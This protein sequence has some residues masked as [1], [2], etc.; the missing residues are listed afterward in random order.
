MSHPWR[1]LWGGDWDRVKPFF[2]GFRSP[3]EVQR[4]AIPTIRS[5]RDAL[6]VAPTAS[7]KTEAILPPLLARYHDE[8]LPD[9]GP[10]VLYVAPTRALVAD[11]VHRIRD[12]IRRM[13]GVVGERTSDRRTW[14]GGDPCTV[15]VTTPESLDS[16]TMRSSES[17]S[18][19]QGFITDEMHLLEGGPRGLQLRLVLERIEATI[20]RRLQHVLAS[21]TLPHLE[22]LADRWCVD[23]ELIEVSGAHELDVTLVRRD[24]LTEWTRRVRHEIERHESQKVLAFANS[25]AGVEELATHLSDELEPD[26]WIVRTHHSSLSRDERIQAEQLFH[27]NTQILVVATSTLEV[28]IDIGDVE[29]VILDKPPFTLNSFLQ[30]LGRGCRRTDRRRVVGISDSPLDARVFEALTIAGRNGRSDGKLTPPLFSVAVQQI[31][32]SMRQKALEADPGR[33]PFLARSVVEGILEPGLEDATDKRTFLDS[34]IGAAVSLD[35]VDCE[36]RWNK[37][38]TFE[39]LTLGAELPQYVES[40]QFHV[41]F[42]PTGG[43]VDVILEGSGRTIGGVAP[44]G[45]SVGGVVQLSG[46]PWRITQIHSD[47][48]VVRPLSASKATPPGFNPKQG[49]N[50]SEELAR[51]VA[52]LVW[53]DWEPGKVAVY[54]ADETY[55]YAHFVGY[56]AAQVFAQYLSENGYETGHVTPYSL[57]TNRR[58]DGEDARPSA[59]ELKDMAHRTPRLIEHLEDLGRLYRKL[60]D[61]FAS[62]QAQLIYDWNELSDKLN[63]LEVHQVERGDLSWGLSPAAGPVHPL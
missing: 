45:F 9:E 4:R 36:E 6:V 35:L 47:K 51:E 14:T 19:V 38:G 31:A 44:G 54:K 21:A 48:L 7:G 5:G 52:K 2:S 29:L 20:G 59:S 30:R 58:W 15:L 62:V 22:A 11:I 25:R 55:L 46:R 27:E 56:E 8:L 34:A 32:S 26:G 43:E 17:L 42:T 39:V 28:G 61:D 57:R 50:A 49:G 1:E 10:L 40:P 13:G 41:T 63:A 24:E 37:S 33:Q 60:R 23:P 12:P 16:I 3:T 53:P 18:A